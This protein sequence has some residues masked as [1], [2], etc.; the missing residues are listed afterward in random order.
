[1]RKNIQKIALLVMCLL[2]NA[3]TTLTDSAGTFT[4]TVVGTN[5][6]HGE[7]ANFRGGLS[8]FSGYV[9]ILR[10]ARA[11]HGAV[12]LLDAGDM[13]QGTLESN[14]NEGAAV[15]SVY[16]ALG[17]DAA[18]IGNHEFDFGPVGE[19][20]I[21]EE[22]G[23]DP[24]GALKL[25]ASEAEF[26]IVAANLIDVETG[27]P[28]AWDNVKPSAMISKRGVKIG[29][30][31]VTTA[32]TLQSTIRANTRGLA[33]APLAPTIER[34]ARALKSD[35]A[36]LVIV[37]AHAGGECLSFEDPTDLS[38]C[39]QD[40][41]IFRVAR[42]LTPGLVDQIIGGHHHEGIAH[43]VN[44]IAITSAYK[45]AVAFDRVDYEFESST[46]ALVAR[47]VFP[48]QPICGHV[49]SAGDCVRHDAPQARVAQYEGKAVAPMPS[50][51]RLIDPAIAAAAS[52]KAEPLGV[53]ALT[54]ITREGEPNAAIGR[55][56]TDAILEATGADVAIHNVA[57]GIRAD[58][59]AGDLTFGD[60]FRVFPFDNR[61][62]VLDVTGSDL[63]KLLTHQVHNA[64]RRAGISG[65]RV[66]VVC[67]NNTLSLTM[68][69]NDGRLIE[70]DD[71]VRLASND[72]LL[73]GG[74]AIF[75]P[76]TPEGGFEI[77]TSQPKV[78]DVWVDWFR[79]R[80]GSLSASDYLTP[81]QTR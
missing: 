13:W 30:I 66:T 9:S 21:P 36:Q 67:Q 7:L 25:R 35:G 20:F 46:G 32:E 50:V 4:I 23:D 33:M 69:L 34:E 37:V 54:P 55:L 59:P 64:T 52:L 47:E 22:P 79:A 75:D 2:A 16:N 24:Q 3:C 65:L 53:T 39:E 42:A 28:I 70:D 31:G 1:M 72:F 12:V 8:N 57:G 60:V 81:E 58:F 40:D 61:I 14:I 77:D 11:P 68:Q 15:V 41:E 10:N 43:V 5:D 44:G 51:Q 38:S 76:I 27:R 17:F 73:L 62:S 6:V 45:S 78:R 56:M 18:T 74:D 80:G 49:D 71:V 48:P 29:V 26:P 63:R 19:R